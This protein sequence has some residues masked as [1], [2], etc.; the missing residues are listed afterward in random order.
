MGVSLIKPRIGYIKTSGLKLFEYFISIAWMR[1]RDK[2]METGG[3][4]KA[5]FKFLSQKPRDKSKGEAS[6]SK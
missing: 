6:K 3:R 5:G 2:R 1:V 4:R